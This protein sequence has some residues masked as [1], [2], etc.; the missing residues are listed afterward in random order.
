MSGF[1]KK[2]RGY[3]IGQTAAALLDYSLDFAAALETGET[4]DTVTWTVETGLTAALPTQTATTA[5]V[6]LSGGAL[7]TAYAVTCHVRTSAGREDDKGFYVL[8]KTPQF[9]TL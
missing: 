5:T 7:N 3:E 4:L 8:I 1:V 6:W 2:S 9:L